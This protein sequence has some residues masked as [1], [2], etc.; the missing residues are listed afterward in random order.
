MNIG[1][2]IRQLRLSKLMTQADLAGDRI[3]RNMLCTIERGA[4][5]PS[6]P[7]AVYLAKR[8]GVPVGLLLAEEGEEAPYHKLLDF[9][10]VKRA[11]ENR[12]FSGCL[13]LLNASF[14]DSEDDEVLLLR[15]EAEY[16]LACSFFEEGRFRR[17]C[18]AFDRAIEAGERS[19]YNTD[20]I[21]I[22]AAVYFRYFGELSPSLA[23][24]ALPDEE[25]LYARAFGDPFCEYRFALEALENEREDEV[26]AYLER[27]DGT[28]YARHV[29]ARLL[30]RDGKYPQA[31]NTLLALL[32]DANL[33]VGGLLY[34]VFGDL[35]VCCRQNDDYKRAYEFSGSRMALFERLLEEV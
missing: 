15:A 12:D 26:C 2:R 11:F 27:H 22:C 24:E 7:T 21:R 31:Q 6:L 20:R 23:S 16:G 30:M 10:N 1:E 18:A 33:S 4:A 35:D 25:V 3:T 19:I 29:S 9:P 5:L 34:E 32:N 28:L 13:S 17:A 14:A 8:L